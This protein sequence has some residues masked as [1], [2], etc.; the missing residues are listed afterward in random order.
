MGCPGS[1]LEQP[2]APPSADA[3]QLVHGDL[4]AELLGDVV[5]KDFVTDAE[6]LLQVVLRVEPG[7]RSIEKPHEGLEHTLS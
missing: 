1:L 6:L 5:E 2:A 4:G 7:I 3:K